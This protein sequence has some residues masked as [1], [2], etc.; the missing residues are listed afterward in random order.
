MNLAKHTPARAAAAVAT[1]VA[2][3]TTVGAPLKWGFMVWYGFSS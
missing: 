1:L 2:L 3:V